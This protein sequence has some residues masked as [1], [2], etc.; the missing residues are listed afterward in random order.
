MENR[1]NP[2]QFPPN[3]G[4]L[5]SPMIGDSSQPIRV[6]ESLQ[7]Q[8]PIIRGWKCRIVSADNPAHEGA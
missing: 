7:D 3:D 2:G 1:P 8:Q 6:V 5:L 4:V